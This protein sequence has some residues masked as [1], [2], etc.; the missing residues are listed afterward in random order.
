MKK[1]TWWFRAP[2]I[3]FCILMVVFTVVFGRVAYA[4]G[5]DSQ[6][7]IILS[8]GLEAFGMFLDWLLE[9]WEAL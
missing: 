6:L 3:L 2:I 7:A 4:T 8:K 5:G 1:V 9:V